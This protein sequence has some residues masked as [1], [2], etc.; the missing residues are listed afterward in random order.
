MSRPG[1]WLSAW[2]AHVF[3][4]RTMKLVIDPA[5]ADLQ[6]EC[7]AT[8]TLRVRLRGYVAVMKVLAVS[9]GHEILDP[10]RWSP[11]ERGDVMRI[12]CW[13]AAAAIAIASALLLRS[14]RFVSTAI[15]AALPFA[16]VI[17]IMIG[18]GR[19]AVSYRTAAG[20]LLIAFAMSVAA[21][22]NTGSMRPVEYRRVHESFDRRVGRHYAPETWGAA[23]VS[24]WELRRKIT[25]ARDR[26][27]MRALVFDYQAEW[28]LIL[29]PVLTTL[30]MLAILVHHRM[31]RPKLLAIPVAAWL[32]LMVSMASSRIVPDEWLP[33][34]I[35][36][37]ELT[38]GLASIGLFM[39]TRRIRLGF[40]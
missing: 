32:L 26:A 2:A 6:N 15:E 17:G 40:E 39:F 29:M 1:D 3:D 28:I 27:G 30:L 24:I 7:A 11:Q 5:V 20:V 19:R 9:I 22:V 12:A 18:I 37:P 38:M 36:V 31:S 16:T 8:A 33:L 25:A 13:S 14:T 10:R 23:D 35:W 4:V 21:L 34:A